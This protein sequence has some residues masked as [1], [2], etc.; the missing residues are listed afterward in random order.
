MRQRD[1]QRQRERD[2]E[3][4]R[5]RDTQRER[6][7]ESERERDS[8][9]VYTLYMYTMRTHTCRPAHLP[10]VKRRVVL[11][12]RE[13]EHV[14]EVDEDAG[15]GVGPIRPEGQPL[16]DHHEDQ[17]AKQAE[18]E[19]QLGE[20]HQEDAAQLAKVSGGRRGD[21]PR[22]HVLHTTATL[23]EPAAF[24]ALRRLTRS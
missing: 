21:P 17:V 22:Q 18:H 24:D 6:E 11:V 20:Q 9:G 2:S 19:K 4:N 15:G 13:E 12:L 23:T 5:E 16:E 10:F 7:R 3:R 14:Y 1:S 8:E